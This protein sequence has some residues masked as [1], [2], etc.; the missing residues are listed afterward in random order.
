VI[1][2]VADTSPLNYLVQINREDILPALYTSV[3][4]PTAVLEELNHPGAVLAVRRWLELKPSWLI[5][6]AAV[7]HAD[8]ALA[9]LDPGE[10]EAIQLAKQEHADL[11]LMDEKLGV[12]VAREQGLAVTGTLGVLVQAARRGL[13]DV[14]P[15]LID[16]QA[17][18]FRCSRRVLEEARRQAKL[19]V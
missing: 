2:V 10:R 16:L 5:V 14:E 4:V 15:A 3:F 1:V 19:S 8:P 11:L 17:T 13:I 12:R 6:R 9:R 18:D 7:S